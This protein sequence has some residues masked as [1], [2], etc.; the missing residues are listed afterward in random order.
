METNLNL[1]DDFGGNNE[2]FRPSGG[3]LHRS[4]K[5]VCRPY[6]KEVLSFGS[7]RNERNKKAFQRGLDK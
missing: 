7:L 2:S 6:G 5:T 1:D 3:K 4:T